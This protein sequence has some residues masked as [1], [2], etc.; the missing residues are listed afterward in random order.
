MGAKPQDLA[1]APVIRP[2]GT[3]ETLLTFS[4]DI[5]SLVPLHAAFRR[6]MLNQERCHMT[7]ATRPGRATLWF[8]GSRFDGP[9]KNFLIATEVK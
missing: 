1:G 2:A 7:R 8:V 3:N 5:H 4:S 6:A 9:T